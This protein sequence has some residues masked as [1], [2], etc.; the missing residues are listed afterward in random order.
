[1]KKNQDNS[2]DEEEKTST[3]EK[4]DLED[5]KSETSESMDSYTNEDLSE[6]T[7]PEKIDTVNDLNEG[8]EF[9]KKEVGY[10]PGFEMLNNKPEYDI[11]QNQNDIQQNQ[12]KN[13]NKKRR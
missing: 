7:P 1:R 9:E 13:T 11:R 6:V 2:F 5:D 10:G 12:I 3:S 8:L 4:T